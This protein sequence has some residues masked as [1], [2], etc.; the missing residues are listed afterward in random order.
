MKEV[1]QD[2]CQ[3]EGR[4]EARCQEEGRKE[5]VTTSSIAL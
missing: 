2:G 5:E 4:E 1:K 3:E